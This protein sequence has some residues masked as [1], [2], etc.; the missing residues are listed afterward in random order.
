MARGQSTVAPAGKLGVI[1]LRPDGLRSGFARVAARFPTSRPLVRATSEVCA[2]GRGYATAAG[3]G[4]WGPWR[5]S[6]FQYASEN[7]YLTKDWD[8]AASPLSAVFPSLP[9]LVFCSMGDICD[10]FARCAPPFPRTA[11]NFG[12]ALKVKP[13]ADSLLRVAADLVSAGIRAP[14]AAPKKPPPLYVPPDQENGPATD[15][16]SDYQSD[17]YGNWSHSDRKWNRYRS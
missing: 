15:A 4:P 16:P 17:W 9:Y 1:P 12:G 11:P 10:L 14:P 13:D 8:W 2:R 5:Y 3:F 7:G 6:A